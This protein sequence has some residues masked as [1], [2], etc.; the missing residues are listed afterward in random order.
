VNQIR[1]AKAIISPIKV[2]LK[3]IAAL[4]V[5]AGWYGYGRRWRGRP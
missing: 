1:I 5:N 2:A 4:P 3:S